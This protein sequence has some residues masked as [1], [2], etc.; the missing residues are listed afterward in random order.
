MK[1][2][3]KTGLPPR[4][5]SGNAELFAEYYGNRVR[6]DHRQK[7]WLLW[8]PRRRWL[9]DFDQQVIVLAK[10]SARY[11]ASLVFEASLEED[12]EKEIQW[13]FESEQRHRIRAAL[14]LARSEKPISCDGRQ[15]DQNP[16]LLGVSNG[17]VDLTTGR[18]RRGRPE[19]WITLSTRVPFNRSA[20]CPRFDQFLE[21][22]FEHDQDLIEFVRRAIGY[23]LT[24]A[25]SEQCFFACYGAGAN[26]KSTLLEVIR[27]VLGDYA[28]ALPFNTL[29][30]EQR[31]S[32]PNDVAMLASKRFATSVETR[33]EV[34]MNEQRIKALTGGDTITAR[35]LY[36]E[37]FKFD[38]THKLWLAFNHPPIIVDNSHA[39]WRRVRMIPFNHRFES[40]EQDKQLPEKLKDEAPGI[41]ALAVQAS[42]EWQRNG[43]GE[44][45]AVRDTTKE[46]QQ[47]MDHVEAFV[48]ECCIE[49]ASLASPCAALWEGY[50][51]FAKQAGETPID[52]GVFS[53]RLE[54][55]GYRKIRHG[56]E[57][58]WMWAGIGLPDVFVEL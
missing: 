20:R 19:D 35:L 36:K 12:E 52:R 25:I 39:M 38:P 5:D 41:L 47:K 43:L 27:Y 13:C 26:G 6:F 1:K 56:H 54:A 33:E 18:L 9:E 30:I 22:V 45:K 46:Y 4:T 48:T 55:R 53:K 23:S 37:F 57:N 15:F 17:V 24:G 10:Q 51:D 58:I 34:R 44:P 8:N 31:S 14:D 40:S 29:E 7:R 42:L 50:Q 2:L 11:R 3:K 16:W 21:E 49:D 32:I 28:V